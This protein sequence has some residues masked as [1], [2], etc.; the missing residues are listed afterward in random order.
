MSVFDASPAEKTKN[1]EL[2]KSRNFLRETQERCA[3]QSGAFPGNRPLSTLAPT[4]AALQEYRSFEETDIPGIVRRGLLKF[5]RKIE[6]RRI[7]LAEQLILRTMPGPYEDSSYLALLAYQAASI[8]MTLNN[9]ATSDDRPWSRVILGTI[10]SPDVNALAKGFVQGGYTTVMVFSAL[11][12]FVYQSAKAAVAAS[13]PTR[14]YDGSTDIRSNLSPDALRR[15]IRENSEPIDR[16]YATLEA[17]FYHGY[18]RAFAKEQVREE[19]VVSL[20]ML[21]GLAERFVVGHEYGHKNAKL[22]KRDPEHS[23]NSKWREEFFA[24]RHAMFI[25][26]M[27]GA[28]LDEINPEVAL[29]GAVFSLTC[30]DILSRSMSIALQ[31]EEVP[32][33]GSEDHPP[34][35]TRIMRLVDGFHEVFDIRYASG[36]READLSIRPHPVS[37]TSVDPA[38]R[39]HVRSGASSYADALMII[40]EQVRD[41]LKRD[42][43]SGRRLHSMWME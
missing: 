5:D 33:E 13:N 43:E 26:V 14:I 28:T 23:S 2:S 18:P 20:G 10:H 40:W 42:F 41:L 11:I 35:K 1:E 9:V 15:Q 19:N 17:Y 24:D 38:I 21:I 3:R 8:E 29:C 4:L 25:N 7:D 31:G 16:L 34:L 39:E 27:S 37:A 12:D 6:E 32:D 30:A 22:T 36:Y